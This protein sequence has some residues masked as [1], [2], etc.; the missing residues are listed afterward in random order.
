MKSIRIGRNKC[1]MTK[2]DMTGHC[3]CLQVLQGSS[4]GRSCDMWG[5][6]CTMIEMASTKAPWAANEMSNH[7]ALIY[8][9]I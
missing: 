6:G 7:L 8:K 5:V 3:T 4:Y 2:C 9:V 1:Q